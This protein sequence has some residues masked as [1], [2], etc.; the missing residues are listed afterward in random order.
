[1]KNRLSFYLFYKTLNFVW[2]FVSPD[3]KEQYRDYHQ[4]AGIKINENIRAAIHVSRALSSSS[5]KGERRSGQRYSYSQSSLS[6]SRQL[7]SI[8]SILSC[9]S[10]QSGPFN[11]QPHSSL[12]NDSHGASRQAEAMPSASADVRSFLRLDWQIR[13]SEN[14]TSKGCI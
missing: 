4:F 12:H 3:V 10:G 14:M 7:L 5:G 6:A 13:S 8:H 11:R 9:S 2:L 1:M